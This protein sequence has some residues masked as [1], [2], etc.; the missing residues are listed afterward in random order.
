[1]PGQ[2]GPE[3]ALLGRVSHW[4]I[5]SQ[6]GFVFPGWEA[7]FV[8]Q[9]I[10]LGIRFFGP[11]LIPSWIP[12]GAGCLPSASLAGT[13]CLSG[14]LSVVLSAAARARTSEGRSAAPF[15]RATHIEHVAH[16]RAGPLPRVAQQ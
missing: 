7:R 1:M 3:G 15:L 4:P 8:L 14:A 2:L 12:M 5:V 10:G 11:S 13:G 6:W 16:R 9:P